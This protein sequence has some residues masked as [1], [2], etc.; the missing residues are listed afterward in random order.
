MLNQAWFNTADNSYIEGDKPYGNLWVS[1]PI[2]PDFT[3]DWNPNQAQWIVN[4]GRAASQ[5]ALQ[6]SILADVNGFINDCVALFLGAIPWN[7][8]TKAYPSL[9][10]A[11]EH[12]RWQDLQALIVDANTK[13][14]ITPQQY[15]SIKQFVQNRAIPIVLP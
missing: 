5:L 11:L 14:A 9:I 4:A 12:Q 1:V 2:R 7:T 6:Q 10:P 3:Y 8:V 13:A 15:N